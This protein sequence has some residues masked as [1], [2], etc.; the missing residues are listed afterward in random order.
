MLQALLPWL[1][2]DRHSSTAR[3]WLAGGSRR[4]LCPDCCPVG[5]RGPAG[6]LLGPVQR[7]SH[8]SRAPCPGQPAVRCGAAEC[9]AM[10]PSAA[11]AVL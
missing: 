5:G 10:R 8:V 4:E 11:N 3:T 9:R 1:A 6:Q 7:L 2:S